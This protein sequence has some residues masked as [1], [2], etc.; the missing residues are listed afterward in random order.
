MGE[1]LALEGVGKPEVYRGSNEE[2]YGEDVGVPILHVLS[3][4]PVAPLQFAMAVCLEAGNGW[5]QES[6]SQP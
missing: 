4:G 1:P 5:H 3:T 2:R 6:C